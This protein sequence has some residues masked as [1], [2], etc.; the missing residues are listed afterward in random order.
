MMRRRLVLA[1]LAILWVAPTFSPRAA[2]GA[3]DELEELMHRMAAR[4]HGEVDFVEQHFLAV[5]KRP[6]ESSGIMIYDAPG[7]LEKRTQEPRPETL[8]LEG[9][10]LTVQR[11]G[12]T[13]VLDL[14]A[15]PTIRPLVE[16]MRATL[17]GDADALERAF[18][19]E[20]AGTPSH[21]M[22]TLSPR[23]AQ[24]ARKISNVRIEGVRENLVKVEILQ[25]DGDRSLMTLR[26]HPIP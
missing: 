25:T 4:R 8:L 17:A 22:L 13:R 20:Y 3:S 2:R 16:S 11:A 9:D 19:V 14:K 18:T 15:Y 12:Q 26:D 7:R 24:V 5:L 10:V 6:V 21:W 1:A 23:D